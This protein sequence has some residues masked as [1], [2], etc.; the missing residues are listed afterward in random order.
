MTITSAPSTSTAAAFE[1]TKAAALDPDCDDE[2]YWRPLRL[3]QGR[4]PNEVWSLVEPLADDDRPDLRRL[5]PDVLRYLGGRPQPLL[6]ETVALVRRM[7]SVPQPPVVLAAVAAAFV[8]LAHPAAAELLKPLVGH[9]D[10]EVR[11]A[12]VHG[13]LPVARLVVPELIQLSGDEVADVR[14]WATFG[15]NTHLGEPGAD[16]FVD[17][18]A[19]RDA[20]AA[21]LDD[22]HDETRAEAVEGLARRRDPRALPVLLLELERV[23]EWHH[24]IEAAEALGDPSLYPALLR[25]SEL[26]EPPFDV[27]A[28][29]EACRP[30]RGRWGRVR[31]RGPPPSSR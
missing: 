12:V 18:E 1:A 6:E 10:P 15:L 8:D 3:L 5:A 24:Y 17:S 16:D 23:P 25:I 21:R 9:P 7:L 27:T 31:W 20:L 22:P 2:A 28:A 19:I 29:L 14:N 11:G 30:G 13:L 26:E 4:N